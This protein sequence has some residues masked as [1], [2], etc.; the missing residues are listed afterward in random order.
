MLQV[1]ARGR[2]QVIRPLLPNNP[3]VKYTLYTYDI[4]YG[5]DHT[6]TPVSTNFEGAPGA[7]TEIFIQSHDALLTSF[8]SGMTDTK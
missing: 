4:R 2:G 6:R 8:W 5:K 7:C 3:F 1:T